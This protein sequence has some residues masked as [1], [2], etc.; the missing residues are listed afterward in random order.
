MV[1]RFPF[2]TSWLSEDSYHSNL[3]I[4]RAH[5]A[6][7][8]WPEISTAQ[9]VLAEW[10]L[11][12]EIYERAEYHI[13]QIDKDAPVYLRGQLAH[14]ALLEQKGHIE[15]AILKITPA[16]AKSDGLS[17]G[18]NSSARFWHKLAEIY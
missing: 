14:L 10:Y 17:A 16:L 11:K 3:L 13:A 9:L 6:T 2:E 1:A 18:E 5:L 4:A 8:I 15:Q 7:S 12:V